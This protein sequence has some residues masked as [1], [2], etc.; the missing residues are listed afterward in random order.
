MTIEGT[1][2]NTS[3]V[4]RT[5]V[6]SA[7]AAAKLCKVYTGRD[8]DGNTHQTCKKED[9]AR[10]DNRVRHASTRLAHRGW[11]VGKEGKIQRA[12]SLVDQVEENRD[13][14]AG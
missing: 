6:G 2:F 10:A 5:A 13:Q 4:K 7:L 8:A 3:A 14:A 11:D 1:P 12:R 9:D